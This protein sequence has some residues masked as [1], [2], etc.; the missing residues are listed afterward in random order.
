MAE[1]FVLGIVIQFYLH[2]VST[3]ILGLD[4]GSFSRV[5]PY[6]LTCPTQK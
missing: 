1:Y 4:M 3:V 5:V 6:G 2:F